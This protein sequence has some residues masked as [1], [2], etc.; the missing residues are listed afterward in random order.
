[1]KC[2]KEMVDHIY[3]EL[4]DAKEYALEAIEIKDINRSLGDT[5]IILAKEE[6]GHMNRLHDQVTGIITEYRNQKGEPPEAMLKIYN[7][8]HKKIME[9]AATVQVLINN[10]K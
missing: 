7:W 3:E 8:E 5:Y 1:M 10:Y 4:D 6:M 9:C 2:I